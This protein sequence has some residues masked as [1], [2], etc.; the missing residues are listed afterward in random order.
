M[1]Y[2]WWDKVINEYVKVYKGSKWMGQRSMFLVYYRVSLFRKHNA[3]HPHKVSKGCCMKYKDALFAYIWVGKC[4]L[5]QKECA[6]FGWHWII[7]D[8][9][10]VWVVFD[11]LYSIYVLPTI[12]HNPLCGAIYKQVHMDSLHS[13]LFR[14]ISLTQTT[15]YPFTKINII[16]NFFSVKQIKADEYAKNLIV[17]IRVYILQMFNTNYLIMFNNKCFLILHVLQ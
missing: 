9:E 3:H 16:K 11:S 6:G 1:C 12:V 13:V 4:L 10:T 7:S 8:T 15:A 17:R 5:F 2:Y 14:T